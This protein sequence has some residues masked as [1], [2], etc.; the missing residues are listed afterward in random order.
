MDFIGRITAVARGYVPGHVYSCPP[1]I[2]SRSENSA[3]TRV[4]RS[5]KCLRE[6]YELV[7]AQHGYRIH[8]RR[9]ARRYGTGGERNHREKQ[10]SNTDDGWIH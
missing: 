9:A 4:I 2:E 8:V 10:R 5:G 3:T 6:H 1:R 7:Q